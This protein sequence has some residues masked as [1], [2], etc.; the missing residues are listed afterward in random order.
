VTV[1]SGRPQGRD[2]ES[3]REEE[4]QESQDADPAER[5]VGGIPTGRG[6]KPLKRGRDGR[7]SV[8]RQCAE[9]R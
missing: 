3:P 9:G 5:S 7:E 4:S 6:R 1:G 2:G 8:A